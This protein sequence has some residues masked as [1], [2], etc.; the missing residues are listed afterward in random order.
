L[1][2][3]LTVPH[4]LRHLQRLRLLALPFGLL[5]FRF[6]A[7]NHAALTRIRASPRERGFGLSYR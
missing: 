2:L 3:N 5:S 6:L 4:H 1:V 7:S